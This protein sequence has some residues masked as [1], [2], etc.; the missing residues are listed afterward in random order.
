MRGG[1]LEFLDQPWGDDTARREIDSGDSTTT[2]SHVVCIS[3]DSN[4][5][6]RFRSL[7]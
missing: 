7:S 5:P 6:C 4:C 2:P 1:E 3:L